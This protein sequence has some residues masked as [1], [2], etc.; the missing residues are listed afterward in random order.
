MAASYSLSSDVYVNISDLQPGSSSDGVK[1][2]VIRCYRQPSPHKTD[3]DG[4]LELILHDEIEDR[5]HAT[6]DYGVFK[7]KKIDIV[8]GG[9]YRIRNFMVAH[10]M[11]KYKTTTN[12]YKLRLLI[13]TSIIP[14]KDNGFPS[15]MHRFRDLFE[16]ANDISVDNFQLLD[17]IGRVVSYQ[18]PTF[19][20]KVETRRMDF[21]IAN[22]EGKELGC[23]LWSNYIDPVLAIFEKED[24]RPIIICIQFGKISRIYD[25]IKVSNTFHV[26]KVTVNGD[27]DVF[28]NFLDGMMADVSGSQKN[29]IAEE[30]NDVYGLFKEN[31]AQMS[32]ISELAVLQEK[33]TYWVDATI[34]EIERKGGFYYAACRKCFKKMPR[35]ERNRQCFICGEDNFTENYRYKIEVLV[36]DASGCANMLMWD[37][38]CTQLIGKPAKYMKDLNDKAGTKIPRELHESLVDK[39]VLFEVKTPSNK[40]NSDIPQFIVQRVANDEDIFDIYAKNYTPTR[41]STTDCNVRV[42]END[43]EACSKLRK[44]KEKMD[45]E[46]LLE[47]DSDVEVGLKLRDETEDDVSGENIQDENDNCGDDV[48]LKKLKNK[49]NAGYDAKYSS[50]SKKLKIQMG[51]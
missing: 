11:S 8:E 48:T 41:G 2:R 21:K 15:S 23:S 40:V 47:N 5:I 18:K 27:S 1:V 33:K 13:K 9:L 28:K 26:T 3:S 19:V 31:S 37:A 49:K 29:G 22:I 7:D 16:I 46:K 50:K 10:D 39:R 6:M 44:G 38:Q 51:K 42:N 4:S 45:F 17:V 34:A 43:D 12:R 14:F 25:E 20:A 35:D 32:Q 36:A 24:S 30:V